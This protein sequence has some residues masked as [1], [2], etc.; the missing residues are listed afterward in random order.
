KDPNCFIVCPCRYD[1]THELFQFSLPPTY[2]ELISDDERESP[3]RTLQFQNQT[4]WERHYLEQASYFGS[5]IF[6]LPSED[7]EN[8]RKKETGPYA[9]DTYGELGRWS[10]K[11]SKPDQFSIHN[12][13]GKMVNLTI[14]A[15]KDFHGLSVIQKNFDADHGEPFPIYSTLEETISEAVKLGKKTNPQPMMMND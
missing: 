13:K 3:T 8:P 1:N 2:D 4:M 9:R 10:L 7:S 6:W 14:G 5:V 15:E 11:S 12:Y